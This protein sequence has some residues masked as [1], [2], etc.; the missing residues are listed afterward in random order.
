VQHLVRARE[1]VAGEEHEREVGAIGAGRADGLE[2]RVERGRL[3]V[4]APGEPGTG[5]DQGAAPSASRVPSTVDVIRVAS[6]CDEGRP[7]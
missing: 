2:R 3:R 1:G 5:A 4:G 6:A 7:V